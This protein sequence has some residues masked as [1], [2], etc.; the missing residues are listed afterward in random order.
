MFDR[1][2]AGEKAVLVHVVHPDSG[3]DLAEF[4]ELV[5][6]SGVSIVGTVISKRQTPDPKL[7]IG[8]GKADE[9]KASLLAEQ[10]DVVIVNHDLSPAQERNLEKHIQC[11]VLSRSGLILDIFAQR[12]RTFEGKLQVELA[13][14]QHLQTRL[15]RGWTHLE[16]Q[17]GGIGLR[18]PGETQLETDRRLLRERIKAIKARLEKVRSQR[19]ENRR[20]R[21]KSQL[22][23]VSLVGYTNAGKSTL[24]NLLTAAKSLAEDKLFATLDPLMRKIALPNDSHVILADTVGFIQK[25]PHQL[26]EA[27]KGTLEETKG[28]DLL[29]HV[30]DISVDNYRDNMA[31]VDEVL[32]EIG[33]DNVPVMRV[34]NKIDKTNHLTAGYQPAA[35][36]PAVWVS[37]VR[38]DGIDLMLQAIATHFFGEAKPYRF[39]LTPQQGKIRALLYQKEAVVDETVDEQGN[40]LVTAKL[41]IKDYQLIWQMLNENCQNSRSQP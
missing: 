21:Q 36:Q 1:H 12:A 40:T 8:T 23:V 17:K 30:V 26:V 33:A 24:F 13:Q 4:K 22:P 35:E 19:E 27:F 18:G 2:Q 25:L 32:K 41:M 16:R 28:A 20:S 31:V 39:V 9:I 29:L 10:A 3:D 11:R 37:A 7:Y 38:G 5:V 14:L 15:V 6:S 34:F